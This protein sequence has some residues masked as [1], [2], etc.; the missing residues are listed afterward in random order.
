MDGTMAI[1]FK[2]GLS[3]RRWVKEHPDGL[4]LNITHHI[5]PRAIMLHRACCSF[6]NPGKILPFRQWRFGKV[7]ADTIQE[8]RSWI[9]ANCDPNFSYQQCVRC[10]P[11]AAPA[12]TKTPAGLLR[13]KSQSDCRD[14][15]P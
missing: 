14:D 5:Q 13:P 6:A 7:G 4:L 1:R 3:F 8:M 9:V 12:K 15:V 2:D 10:E 11:Q